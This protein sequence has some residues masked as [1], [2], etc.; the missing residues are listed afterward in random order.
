MMKIDDQIEDENLQ[1]DINRETAK[2]SGKI[3]KYEF[4][5]DEEILPSNQK[6]IIEQ[7]KIT[8]SPLGNTFEIQLKIKEKIKSMQK[9]GNRKTNN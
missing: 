3:G 6:Q 4:F 8:Y 7:T 9:K 2:I 1:Y 5:T